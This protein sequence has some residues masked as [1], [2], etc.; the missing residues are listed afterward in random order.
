[1]RKS[2]KTTQESFNCW[3]PSACNGVAVWNSI[4]ERIPSGMICQIECVTTSC[5]VMCG[6]AGFVYLCL[7]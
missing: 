6:S 4:V 3:S 2:D 5:S 1:M 7:A